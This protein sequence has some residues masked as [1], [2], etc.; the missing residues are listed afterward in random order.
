MPVVSKHRVLM[1]RSSGFYGGPERQI[2][3]HALASKES[4]YCVVV[5]AFSVSGREPD[6]LRITAADGI[7]TKLFRTRN[8]YHPSI[9]RQVRQFLIESNIEILATHDYR[10]TLIGYLAIRKTNCNWLAWSRG[11][12]HEG[13]KMAFFQLL[14]KLIVRFADR[15]LVV[16]NAQQ[17]K[18]LRWK[19]PAHKC[20]VVHNAV[21]FRHLKQIKT[22]NLRARFSLADDSIVVATAG[23]FSSEKGQHILLGVIDKIVSEV[24]KVFFVLFGDGPKLNKCRT[25]ARRLVATDHVFLPGFENNIVGH[26]QDADILVNPS[27]TEGLP[28]IVLEAMA[29]EIP[30]VAT[31]VGG[32]PELIVDSINGRLVPAGNSCALANAIIELA[33]SRRLQ[34]KFAKNAYQTIVSYFTFT[35]QTQKLHEIYTEVLE[36][37]PVRRFVNELDSSAD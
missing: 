34:E 37:L 3:E 26:L 21:N 19:I 18:L 7:E 12:T 24:P 15:V 29:L 13:L 22:A 35:R 10:A 33:I 14:E 31:A 1:L 9:I 23:R 5:G 36:K 16:A 6:L 30:T 27:L 2:H 20:I 32:V 25:M 8:N 17:E 4:D 28:N 11:W